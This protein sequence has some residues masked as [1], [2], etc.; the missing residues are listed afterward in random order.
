MNEVLSR[1]GLSAR[2]FCRLTGWNRSSL[3]YRP[4]GRN[5][6]ALRERLRYWAAL[7]AVL[8]GIHPFTMCSEP[9]VSSS[10]TNAPS[11]SIV[12]DDS[13]RRRRRRKLPAVA[14]VSLCVPQEPNER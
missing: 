2:G 1:F 6:A 12:R 14:R 9:K 3:R 8:G 10:I 11:A 13:L 7:Q 5:D 4:E